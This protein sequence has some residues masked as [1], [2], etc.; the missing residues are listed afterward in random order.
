MHHRESRVERHLKEN[1]CE[2]VDGVRI[3]RAR[4]DDD[5]NKMTESEE[6]R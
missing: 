6:K 3:G 5:D 4:I 1:T 2:G